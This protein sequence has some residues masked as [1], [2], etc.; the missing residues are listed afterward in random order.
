M[1]FKDK[2]NFLLSLLAIFIIVALYALFLGNVWGDAQLRA[3]PEAD[4]LRQSWLT[5]GILA[6]STVTTSMGAFAVIVDDRV[7]KINKAFY[8]SPIKRRY[9]TGGYIFSAFIISLIM[10]AVS[11][12]LLGIH[13]IAIG[14]SLPTLPDFLKIIGIV[15]LSGISGTA[16]VCFIVSSLKTHSA[17]GTASTIMGTFIGFL[18][19]IY[20]PIGV[21]PEAVQTVIKLFPPSHAA[22]LLR[23]VLMQTPIANSFEG[24]PAEYVNQFEESMGVVFRFG[25][26]EITPVLSITALIVCSLIFYALAI[27]NMR[28]PGK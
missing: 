10:T 15:L 3:L 4:V 24:I 21:L 27:V 20:L 2:I 22:M 17:F 19:G 25:D 9:I 1:Y 23:R 6:V 16:M 28:K 18:M 11:A 26:F 7:K 12:V 13:L 8:A 14:G 5:A